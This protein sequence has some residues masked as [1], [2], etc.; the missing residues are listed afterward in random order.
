MSLV[1]SR[2]PCRFSVEVIQYE[3]SIILHDQVVGRVA[4]FPG[5]AAPG[6]CGRG[7]VHAQISVILHLEVK[8]PLALLVGLGRPNRVFGFE[9]IGLV[10]DQVAVGLDHKVV[11][12]VGRSEHE[13]LL[14]SGIAVHSVSVK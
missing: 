5:L 13:V 12:P 3:I 9:Y 2:R 7:V 6:A 4:L 14:Q 10:N 8:R 11:R 1:G